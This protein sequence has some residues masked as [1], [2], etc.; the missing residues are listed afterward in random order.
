MKFR[1][2]Y[3]YAAFILSFA[4]LTILSINFYNRLKVYNRYSTEV[5]HNY[6]VMYLLSQVDGRFKE[7]IA[8]ERGYILTRD[9]SF[10]QLFAE[11]NILINPLIDSVRTLSGQNNRQV[12]NLNNLKRIVSERMQQIKKNFNK[13]TL[14]EIQSLDLR[15]LQS[16]VSMREY[17]QVMQRLEEEE[18]RLLS[19]RNDQKKTYQ[20]STTPM[21]F[22]IF[23]LATIIF[24]V[25][26]FFIIRELRKRLNFQQQLQ[27]QVG[28]LNRANAELEQLTHA[29][30]HHLQE[31]LRKIRTFAN[32]LV[33]HYSYGFSEEMKMLLNK[34]DHSAEHMHG[35][36][37]DMV[38]YS[39]L[40]TAQEKPA[41]VDLNYIVMKVAEQM[42][43]RLTL[44]GA[45]MVVSN[46]LPVITGIPLQLAILFEQLIDNSLKFSR[47]EVS[48]I[49]TIKLEDTIGK[50]ISDKVLSVFGG[51]LYY[52][53]SVTDN[54]MGFSNEFAEKIFQ[55]FQKLDAQPVFFQSKGIGLAM[56]QRIMINHGGNVTAS[57]VAGDGAIFYLYF[58]VP[59]R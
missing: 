38:K 17:Y 52:R 32:R 58:P 11:N 12:V 43:E 30:S 5:E 31:P 27:Q 9:S 23:M 2:Q 35:L 16:K 10:L 19:I 4:L 20:R 26:F 15:M 22:S 48:S 55:M 39:N 14:G 18:K 47:K 37:A 1:F 54:G 57:G 50:K 46:T 8:A 24:V 29:A 3:I 6:E 53:I 36:T 40:I 41:A 34:I 49:I 28:E 45:K 51:T 21:L 13:A 25:S 44:S 33:S 42:D 7:T 59:N 56:V